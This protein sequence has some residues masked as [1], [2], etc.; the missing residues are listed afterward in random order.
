MSNLLISVSLS[1]FADFSKAF[2]LLY[3]VKLQVVGVFGKS[4]LF[5]E[6]MCSILS[7]AY[8]SVYTYVL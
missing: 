7:Y 2:L 1:G 8:T 4:L 5:N 3:N 6:S